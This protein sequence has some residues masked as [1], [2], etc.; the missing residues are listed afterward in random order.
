A[1]KA[2]GGER[3]DTAWQAGAAASEVLGPEGGLFARIDPADLGR[4]T[5]AVLARAAWRPAEVSAAWQ[6]FLTAMVQ[7]GPAAIGRRG[8]PTSAEPGG[9]AEIADRRFADPAWTG[10]PAYF[11]MLQAYLATKRFADD[12]LT[13]GRGDQRTDQ[14]AAL[15]VGF[16]LDAMAPTN[17]LLTNPA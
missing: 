6:R 3:E 10:N 12:L 8:G 4:S 2:P 17:F 1:S 5:L 11:A 13:A 14:K 15:A 9:R 16:A 7:A